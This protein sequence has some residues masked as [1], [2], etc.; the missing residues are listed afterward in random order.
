ML[1]SFASSRET[2]DAGAET[3]TDHPRPEPTRRDVLKT[4]GH[5]VI[6][7]GL[8]SPF[9]ALSA[10]AAGSPA[11][12]APDV[13]KG[14]SP[15]SGTGAKKPADGQAGKPA[16]WST[17][18]APPDKQP[19]DLKV[20]EAPRTKAGW[21]IVGLGKL[22]LEEVLPAFRLC[23]RSRPVAL[24]SGHADKAK[25]VARAYG[26]DE[27]NVYDYAGMDRLRDNPEVDVVYVITPN[28][29]HAEH[30]VRG[31]RAGKH[32]LCE[33]P[34]ASS[35]EEC[36]QMVAAARQAGRKLMIAYR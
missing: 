3:M 7:A 9:V 31:L 8:A 34:M 36:E 6:A 15:S 29:L 27:K 25:Q 16:D 4:A 32:V 26:I 33:K 22:A 14:G 18:L 24:V 13:P 5:G 2:T 1:R 30:T 20:P 12:P 19:P 17:P 23:E 10:P 11:N 35:I 21:A 28:S